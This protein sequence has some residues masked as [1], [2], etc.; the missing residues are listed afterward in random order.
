MRF[1]VAGTWRGGTNFACNVLTLLG[2]D[3][4]HESAFQVASCCYDL[5]GN[6]AEV[7]PAAACHLHVIG[8]SCLPLV[9]LIRPRELVVAS[10]EKWGGPVTG[11]I[12]QYWDETHYLLASAGPVA[13][14]YL[15]SDETAIEGFQL[16]GGLL[17]FPRTRE[18]VAEAVATADRKTYES[19]RND[20]PM[21]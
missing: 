15:D 19:V 14:I 1:V 9:Q 18:Q 2:L 13:T 20:P 7:S 17:G 3:C 8:A 6:D 11:N 4:T 12:G 5:G 21:P 16:A 10:M